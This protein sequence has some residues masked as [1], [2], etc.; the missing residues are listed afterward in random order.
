MN[1]NYAAGEWSLLQDLT[2]VMRVR[3]W[4]YEGSH[5]A[6]RGELKKSPEAAFAF[7]K[8]RAATSG[9]LPFLQSEAGGIVVK[10]VPARS[11]SPPGRPAV[12]VLLLLITVITT[13]LAGA[14]MEGT[15]PEAMLSQPRLL[16]RG[17]PF[18]FTLLTILGLHEFS[19]Y[20]VSKKRGIRTSLPYFIPFPNILG[21]MGAVIVSRSPFPDRRS[22]FDVGVAGPLAS[23]FLSVAAILIGFKGISL[24]RFQPEILPPHQG[25]FYFGDSL[26]TKF[27]FALRYHPIPPGYDISL[28][29]LAL[30]GWVG[31]FVTALNLMPMGQLDGGHISYA[32]FGRSHSLVTKICMGVLILVSLIYRSPLWI[33]I[34]LF[35]IILGRG[36]TPPLNDVTTLNPA[37]VVIACLAFLILM[38]CF[39]PIP[40]QIIG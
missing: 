22:L 18:S 30:A 35:I 10:F 13:V 17:V 27:L 28:G 1:Q 8:E 5:L 24:V 19:H 23:F 26:L 6:F 36:H 12:H 31:L 7:I 39:I 15:S 3:S 33:I 2:E 37:R 40:I 32:L 11:K 34:V 29:P 16:L 21:T 38:L 9:L 20:Y 14:L 4:G 25:I